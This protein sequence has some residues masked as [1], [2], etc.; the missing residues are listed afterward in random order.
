MAEMFSCLWPS[1][2]TLH[3]V[4]PTSDLSDYMVDTEVYTM[5]ESV[6]KPIANWYTDQD[7]RFSTLAVANLWTVAYGATSINGV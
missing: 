5:P 3:R 1:E 4:T 2:C 7:A 6:S